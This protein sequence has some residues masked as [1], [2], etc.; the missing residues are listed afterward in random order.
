[1]VQIPFVCAWPAELNSG[2]S[3]PESVSVLCGIEGSVF[4]SFRG[5]RNLSE[6]I[7]VILC[8]LFLYFNASLFTF[9]CAGVQCNFTHFTK[10]Q[11]SLFC[12]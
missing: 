1:M 5:L 9:I 10:V 2:F 7:G 4:I 12:F 6:F 11:S 3:L 8:R